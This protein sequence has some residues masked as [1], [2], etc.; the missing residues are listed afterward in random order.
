[1][2]PLEN[3]SPDP[4]G[5]YFADGIHDEILSHRSR[6]G[7]LKVISRTSVMGYRGT[8]QN[9]RAISAQLGVDHIL[10]GTVRRDRDRVRIT[11]QLIDAR[12]DEHL[13]AETYDRRL[14]DVFAFQAGVATHI[15]A[16]LGAQLSATEASRIDARPTTSLEAYTLYRQGQDYLRRPG[17][18]RQDTEVAEQLLQRAVGLDRDFALARASLAD[19]HGLMHW[20]RFDSTPDRVRRKREEADAALRLDP[21]LPQAHAAM[22]R[23]HYWGRRDYQRAF[24]ELRTVLEGL[25]ND[26][27]LWAKI[28]SVH[29]R[30]GTGRRPS[31][32]SRGRRS[33]IPC[34]AIRTISS[35]TSTA[36][37]TATPT[38]WAR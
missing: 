1:M 20:Y 18:L 2:L 38:P 21:E 36:R 27:G 3:L 37:R 22:A 7:S 6:I 5:A 4:H 29:R 30:R 32:R 34:P 17:V 25:P 33:S 11:A 24:D 13:W 31:P 8:R 14:D 12:S 10:D 23:T 35:A 19:V 28:G 16:S 26:A 9:L 15:A